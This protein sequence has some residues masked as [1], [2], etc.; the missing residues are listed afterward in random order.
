MLENGIY[1]TTRAPLDSTGDEYHSLDKE[2]LSYMTHV[3]VE[4]ATP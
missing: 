3:M 4:A 2:H 1:V